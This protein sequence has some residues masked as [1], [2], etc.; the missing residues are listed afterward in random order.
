M[1]GGRTLS[2]G[3]VSTDKWHLWAWDEENAFTYCRVP[4]FWI[5]WQAA[6]PILFKDAPSWMQ[7]SIEGPIG[8]NSWIYP[9]YERMIMGD[10]HSVRILILLNVKAAC[11][12]IG[13][14]ALANPPNHQLRIILVRK[15][16]GQTLQQHQFVEI[17][18]DRGCVV[19]EWLWKFDE[20]P[21]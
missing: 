11:E 3:H 16:Q 2:R 13:L 17:L 6:P 14:R 12:S 7:E 8:F 15:E 9:C 4:P 1:P 18:K 19:S 20:V 21:W 5:E 10:A